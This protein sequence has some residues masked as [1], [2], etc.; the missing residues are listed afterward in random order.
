AVRDACRCAAV[1][2]TLRPRGTHARRSDRAVA[3]GC[4][5]GWCRQTAR[6]S[7]SAAFRGVRP[8]LRL[9]QPDGA[10]AAPRTHTGAAHRAGTRMGRDGEADRAR[11]QEPAHADQALRPAPA[12]RIP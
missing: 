7:A 3:P 11:D 1:T 8:A 10:T 2:R 9:V 4:C 5:S 12:P 6:A